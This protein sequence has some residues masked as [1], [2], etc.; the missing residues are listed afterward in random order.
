[1]SDDTSPKASG[2]PGG[3]GADDDVL[4]RAAHEIRASRSLEALV[5]LAPSERELLADA[6]IA[7]VLGSAGA[8]PAVGAP[9]PSEPASPS[10]P[11][12]RVATGGAT[13]VAAVLRPRFA[14]RSIAMAIAATA[15][16]AAA[17]ALVVR[18]GHSVAPLATYK[19]EVA[20]EAPERGAAASAPGA[21]VLVHPETRL[22]IRL[23]SETPE[24][25]AL[26]RTVLVHG[27]HAEL[28]ESSVE[29]GKT[30]IVIA[31]PADE[32]LGAPQT[33]GRGEIV[34][35]LGRELPVDDEIR[36]LALGTGKK[37]DHIQVLRRDVIL[38][39][40][41]RN[42]IDVLFGGCRAVVRGPDALDGAPT[43]E[44]AAGERLHLWVGAPTRA[45]ITLRLD[46]R[47]LEPTAE[48]RD[49]GSAFDVD[50]SPRTGLLS[51]HMEGR[52]IAA[53]QVAPVAT[54]E[55]VG[56]ADAAI[57]DGEFDV[58]SAKLD[59]IPSTASPEKWLAVLQARA[60]IANRRGALG[61][62][63]A[64]RREA[65]SRAHSLGRV[66]V[67]TDQ[68]IALVNGLIREHELA[69]A[70]RLLPELAAAGS[71]YPEGAEDRELFGGLLA[72][73]LGELGAA[74]GAFQRALAIADRIGDATGRGRIFG[75]LADVLQSLGRDRETAELVDAEIQ[76]SKQEPDLCA[77]VDALTTSAWLLRDIDPKKAQPLAD[78][79]A[80]IAAERCRSV[81]PLTLLNQ[82]L[83]FAAAGRFGDARAVVNR[84]ARLQTRDQRVTAWMLRLE[85]ETALG[86]DPAGAE[87]HARQ[88]AARADEL[89]SSE[90][91]YEAQLLRARAL[92][93]LG[94]HDQAAAA[95][96]AAD[97]A[98][99]LW[100]RL[101][102][103]GE[104]R[105]TFFQR[106]DQ[107]ARAAIPYY[108]EQAG[109]NRPGAR[110]ALAV[111]VR[112]GIARFIASLERS[113]RAHLRAARGGT[114]EPLTKQFQQ[115]VDRWNASPAA[116]A[117]DAVVGVCKARDAALG[118]DD[119]AL[120]DPP[121][122]PAL[123]VHPTP[124]G[125]LVLVWHGPSIE[126]LE[127]PGAGAHEGP[128][129]LSARIA[130]AAAEMLAGAASVHLHLHRSIAALPLDRSL[131]AQLR[132]PVAFAVDTGAQPPVAPCT[133]APR[134]LLVTNPQGNLW[135]ASQSARAIEG[136]LTRM[137][138]RIDK[139]EGAAATRAAI[140]Q[141]FADPCTVLFQYDG[142][143]IGPRGAPDVARDR[144]DDA[145]LLADDT[146]TAAEVLGLDRVPAAVVLNGCTTAAPEGLGLAQAF[147][148]AG[149]TQVIASLEVIPAD[150]AARFTTKLFQGQP[151][152]RID[153]VRLHARA[154]T[155][156]NLPALRVFER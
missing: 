22:V 85:A 23:A 147:L 3:P 110:H 25:D 117:S 33:D 143:G 111:T 100:S 18:G 127:L 156:I 124:Q 21:P 78:Q 131:A 45:A 84:I 44:V 68:T 96:E 148:F 11:A 65:I 36:R 95:F 86:E 88:L 92:V 40:F 60:R 32:L 57:N 83:L 106:H 126:Y 132:K 105:E 75:S 79:A 113:S 74:L 17:V 112:R 77:R 2:D 130:S 7:R 69:E 26:L 9:V 54:F 121:S 52:K 91:A 6:A 123:F 47:E 53:R 104:G 128:G 140:E 118:G 119:L 29:R 134:A 66:S 80:R 109:H 49:G 43:C 99:T 108:L 115:T 141:R 48:P 90:L 76:R 133:G 139:L 93:A 98:L 27:G 56:A 64:L 129:E 62:E 50:L 24:R 71:V 16:L 151:A 13:A 153:L 5:P 63:R 14:R 55:D 38:R 72:S 42:A 70:A 59:A 101:V 120:D 102:P 73:E 31:G 51:V 34:V 15:S 137:G 150:D 97:R 41:S 20:G 154:L 67:E 114:G 103:L 39:G 155:D 144:V 89:C 28:V 107:L 10:E 81:E 12:T 122:R 138:L 142:H 82:G 149:A 35:I 4:R 136:D 58:A 37:P 125:L 61:E 94:R 1:M 145:L 116:H 152:G 30:S 135:A 87:R 146:L 8:S 46:D 19:L